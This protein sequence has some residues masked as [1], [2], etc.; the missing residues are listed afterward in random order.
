MDD[1]G[2]NN[3]GDF[4]AAIDEATEEEEGVWKKVMQVTSHSHVMFYICNAT[5]ETFRLTAASWDV[6]GLDE[7]YVIRPWDYLSF[8]LREEIPAFARGK[9]STQAK[10]SFS[11]QSA[12]EAFEFSTSLKVAK[13]FDPFAFTPQTIPQ[14]THGIK[15]T[16][17][18]SL[19]C[20]S[21]ITRAMADRP[22]HY[23][24]VIMLGDNF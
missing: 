12:N 5:A 1:T 9:L 15:S 13:E 24:V 6:N 18:S 17:K 11:Y 20:A 3:S 2:D 19:K 23:G 10:H 16:G 7:K 22:Y 21:H 14:R 8:V 4:Q